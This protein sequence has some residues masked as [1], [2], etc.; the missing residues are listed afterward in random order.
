MNFKTK[1]ILG[2]CLVLFSNVSSAALLIEPHLGYNLSGSANYTGNV[3]AII[4][5]QSIN[6]PVGF[7]DKYSG[8]QYGGRIGFQ[9]TPG[10]MFGLDYNKS[11]YSVKTTYN[12]GSAP[13]KDSYDR[14]EIGA[15]LGASLPWSLR[16]WY[17]YY[18][19]T[20]KVSKSNSVS[21]ATNG[22]KNDGNSSEIGVG[23]S[24]LSFMSVNF[25][26]RT[27][28]Y[29][30]GDSNSVGAYT[31]SPKYKAHEIVLGLSFPITL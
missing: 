13:D 5:G 14:S 29:K 27:I 24:P 10:I 15:F 8:L 2:P 9:Y 31:M 26:Y 19:M 6:V 22:D 7:K 16:V 30:D 21:G 23:Y 18:I 11:S 28:T 20:L 12:D 1:I 25:L 17:S 4:S 3:N